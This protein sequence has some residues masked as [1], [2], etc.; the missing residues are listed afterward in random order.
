MPSNA[1]AAADESAATGC[2]RANVPA[3]FDMGHG[4]DHYTYN[5]V[6]LRGNVPDMTAAAP[7]RLPAASVAISVEEDSTPLTA[8]R[9]DAVRRPLDRPE[10]A[11]RTTSAPDAVV[12][13]RDRSSWQA[14][15]RAL[16][17]TRPPRTR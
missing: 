16:P 9:A 13:V 6:R 15:T 12:A 1:S 8:L 5:L 7:A 4:V 14:V 10:F 2:P 11:R 17:G 3:T